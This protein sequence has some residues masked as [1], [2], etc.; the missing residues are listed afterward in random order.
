M[1]GSMFFWIQSHRVTEKIS[2]YLIFLLLSACVPV[3]VPPQVEYTPGAPFTVTADEFIGDSF[4]IIYPE[5]WR[6]I[7]NEASRP[8]TVIFASPDNDALLMIASGAITDPP[9]PPAAQGELH[10]ESETLEINGQ[11]IGIYSAAPT[12]Q[13]ERYAPLFERAIDTLHTP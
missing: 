1:K 2:L 4:R 7:T 12:D 10:T 8:L 3:N 13:W 5:G 6:V 9:A 11:I